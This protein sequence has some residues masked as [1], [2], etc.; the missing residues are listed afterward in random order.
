MMLLSVLLIVSPLL[1][2]DAPPV[3]A[4]KTDKC[5]VCGM[6]VAK[7][8]DFLAQIIF[9]DGTYALFDGAKDMYKYYFDLKKYN[10]S[11]K[12]SDIAAVYVTDY[13]GLTPTNGQTAWYVIGSNVFGPMGRELIPFEKEGEATEFMKDHAGKSIVRFDTVTPDLIKGLD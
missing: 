13:Y 3:K 10:A 8:P 5:P 6:F 4:S 12:L 9:T 11:K 2:G 1:A 7:Y